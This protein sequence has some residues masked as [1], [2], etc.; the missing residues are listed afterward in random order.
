MALFKKTSPAEPVKVRA[1]D[2]F[3]EL[4]KVAR[5]RDKHGRSCLK[6]NVNTCGVCATHYQAV[7]GELQRARA[8][9]YDGTFGQVMS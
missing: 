2:G 4:E 1:V 9:G 8:A 3:P 7:M 6:R 5:A